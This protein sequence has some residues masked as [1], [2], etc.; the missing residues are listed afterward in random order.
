MSPEKYELLR[1][2]IEELVSFNR[3]IGMRLLSAADGRAA[4]RF[5][6]RPELIG[7]F[8]LG[9]LHGG[10]ISS[11]LDVIGAS[12]VLSTFAD[13]DPLYGVGTVDL[14]T[15]FLRPGSGS[16]FT[17]TGQV[18]RPGRILC[19]TRMELVND[20]GDLI[21]IGQAIYRVSKREESSFMTV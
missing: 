8:R 10:V 20:Q 14:R 13:E 15:D 17:A 18:M 9:V 11:A 3:V 5:D 16:Y 2:F 6:F 1:R 12:A 19:S 7:N 21:A 4:L